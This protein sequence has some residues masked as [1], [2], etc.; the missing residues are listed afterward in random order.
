MGDEIRDQ[1]TRYLTIA[2]SIE[3]Q[4]L[5][6]LR[7]APEIAGEPEFAEALSRHLRETEGHESGIRRLLHDRGA[8]PSKLGDAAMRAGGRG[9]VLFA[10]TQTDTPGKLASHA[11]SYEAFEWA[12]H[13]F[14]SLLAERAGEPDVADVTR[15]IQQEERAMMERIEGL[16]D[17]T[18]A[19]SIESTLRDDPAALLGSYLA[20]AHAIEAQSIQLLESGRK[21]IDDPP[22]RRIFEDHLEASRGQQ[23]RLEDALED[24]D[25]SR[26]LL[27]DAAMRLGAL[28]WGMFFQAQPDTSG[29][30]VV[31]AYAF[32]HLEIGGYEQL[33]RVADRAGEAGTSRLVQGI[34]DEERR[35]AETLAEALEKAADVTFESWSST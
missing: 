21:M 29:K 13:R 19:A 12:S 30:L 7:T 22:L 9:F 3:E 10:R 14:L 11:L 16:L 25:A 6:Q 18:A 24:V 15:S 5:Q 31:F 2:H 4:A 33:S 35:T 17:A 27:K 32:E 28:N 8:S 34:I 1:L 20:D 26:S 23:E